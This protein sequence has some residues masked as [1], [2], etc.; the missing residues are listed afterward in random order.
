MARRKERF[1]VVVWGTG[2]VGRAVLREA[3]RL[4]EIDV[5]GVLVYTP[6]KT[7]ADAGEIIGVPPYG[8][9]PTMDREAVL[10][11]K[12]DVILYTPMDHGD[13]RTDDEIIELLSRGHNILTSVAYQNLAMRGPEVEAAFEKACRDGNATFCASG[14]N[15]GFMMERLAATATGATNQIERID[16]EEFVKCG[17][18]TAETLEAFGFGMPMPEPDVKSPTAMIAEQ[19]ERQFIYYL[20]DLFGTPIEELRYSV[21]FGPRRTTSCARA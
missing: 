19:Y 10:A 16:L 2:A 1:R 13:Y 17:Q 14:I 3:M 12:P 21:N 9:T 20:G 11:L 7:E 8:V 5:V 4:P 15:P 18:E 6:A